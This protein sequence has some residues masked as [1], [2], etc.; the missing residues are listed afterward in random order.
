MELNEYFTKWFYSVVIDRANYQDYYFIS[1][2]YE[3]F[4]LPE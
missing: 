2:T 1:E 4:M 3:C